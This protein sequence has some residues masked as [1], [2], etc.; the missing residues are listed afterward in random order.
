MKPPTE[1]H[2]P[3]PHPD[4]FVDHYSH[5]GVGRIWPFPDRL[6]IVTALNNP[7]RWRARYHNYWKFAKHM[8]D[9]GVNLITVELAYGDR[10]FEVTEPGNPHH[11]QFRSREELWHKENLLNLGFQRIPL[12]TKYFGYC[13]ADF[14]FTRPDWAQEVLHQLQ[15]Y[16]AVQP[17]SSF[18]DLDSNHQIGRAM[19]SFCWNYIQGNCIP[20]GHYGSRPVGAVGG[21]WC[22]RT[23]AFNALGGLL[24]TCILGSG[25]W[26]M[27]M[28][29]AGRQDSNLK[30]LG[31]APSYVKSIRDWQQNAAV[32]KKNIGC[33]NCHAIHHWHGA[34]ANR[35]YVSRYKI[36]GNDQYDPAIDIKR[37]WQ[38]VYQLSGNK[39]ELRD[40]L[41]AYFR[42][43]FE[44]DPIMEVP[45]P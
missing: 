16:D 43:R 23:E 2:V 3:T 1:S 35:Q 24:D 44:D 17:Y 30:H 11:I 12:G 26:H 42:S 19:P 41:R 20:P 25:D 37:D 6:F 14:T 39:P 9:S 21:A 5:T 22:Y 15:H 34:K 45:R 40:D 36:L 13:D 29:I 32:L 27:A 33:V 28:G 4:S 38:G 31:G 18:S 10:Q 8:E 7:L